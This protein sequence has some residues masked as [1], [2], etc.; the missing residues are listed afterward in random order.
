MKRFVYPMVIFE[1]KDASEYTVLFPDLD[2]VASG[3]SV[4]DA[5]LKGQDYLNSYIDMCVKFDSEL[6][7]PS[8][9]LETEGMNPK[10]IV[11]LADSEVDTENI[12]LSAEEASYK[13]SIKNVIVVVGD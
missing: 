8:T 3:D 13:A 12:N 4:E 5:F 1:D 9:F 2:I 6:A 11:L 7:S 10:R